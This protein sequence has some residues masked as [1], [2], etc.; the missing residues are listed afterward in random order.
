VVTCELVSP[1]EDESRGGK[2][3][4]GKNKKQLCLASIGGRYFEG[5][6]TLVNRQRGVKLGRTGEGGG[7]F[8]GGEKHFG[9]SSKAK[10]KNGRGS[11]KT[12][13][14]LWLTGKLGT[15]RTRGGT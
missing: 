14:R 4:P 15:R 2:R 12:K 13:I 8:G 1:P 9:G 3:W 6:W 5:K 7:G 11:K 10:D